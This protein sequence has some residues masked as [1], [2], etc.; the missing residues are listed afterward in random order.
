MFYDKIVK[1]I[2]D[3]LVLSVHYAYVISIDRVFKEGNNFN[4]DSDN[5]Q[6]FA[7]KMC[8]LPEINENF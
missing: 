7:R 4:D 1:R 5:K 8:N 3:V 6:K 2:Y